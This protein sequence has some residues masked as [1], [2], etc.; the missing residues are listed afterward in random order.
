MTAHFSFFH[1]KFS[2]QVHISCARSIASP[3][4]TPWTSTAHSICVVFYL[5]PM[6]SPCHVHDHRYPHYLGLFATHSTC[7]TLFSTALSLFVSP[8]AH[9]G[10]CIG[11]MVL[12][13]LEINQHA[14]TTAA[15]VLDCCSQWVRTT[16]YHAS[17][18]AVRNKYSSQ[19]VLVAFATIDVCQHKSAFDR[20]CCV[21]AGA[22]R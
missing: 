6:I 1:Q 18:T 11:T 3:L 15:G 20:H 12:F 2:L 16:L 7:H 17:A 9:V 14:A 13:P 10:M 22:G 5:H 21:V 4:F 8:F 19:N